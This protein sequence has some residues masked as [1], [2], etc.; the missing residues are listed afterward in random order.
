MRHR[1]GSVIDRHYA[2]CFR[3]EAIVSVDSSQSFSG[4]ELYRVETPSGSFCLR[5][6][7]PNS[8]PLVRIRGLHQ[9]L[10]HLF[11]SGM[12]QVA[13]PLPTIAGA[14]TFEW[15][16]RVWHLEP[17]MPGVADFRGDPQPEKLANAMIALAEWHRA[18]ANWNAPDDCSQW[19]GVSAAAPSPAALERLARFN[20]WDGENLAVLRA[21][22]HVS[23]PSGWR[24][25]GTRFLSHFERL[26][27]IVRDELQRFES[28]LLP[29]Q[30]CLRD[31]WSEHVLFT[32]T[33]V[34]GLI[35]PTAC[36]IDHVAVDLA[37]LLGSF[38]DD[39]I[40]SW[41]F[42]LQA[43]QQYHPLSDIELEYVRVLDR[44]STLL[45]GMNWLGRY[46]LQGSIIGNPESAL[47]RLVNLT[48]RI[49][50]INNTS[51]PVISK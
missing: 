19:F 43:Y 24:E 38:L 36:R 3:P 45:S 9:L 16:N 34:T 20:E 48:K 1:L 41:K 22:I 23:A 15:E 31:I 28:V 44:S 5:G 18:A 4:A 27:K 30:P 12:T 13:V 21:R 49:E 32:G 35:D 2:S 8:L 42:A 25:T 33:K 47:K 14:T 26:T 10:L 39:D 11:A 51:R 50:N 17:W 46:F 6:W 37:R 7:P 29:L 40:A